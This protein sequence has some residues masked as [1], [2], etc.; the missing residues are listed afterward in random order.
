MKMYDTIVVPLGQIRFFKYQFIWI[1]LFGLLY[2]IFK[3]SPV[4]QKVELKYFKIQQYKVQIPSE[5]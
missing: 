3:P 4:K 5:Y 2:I 1:L